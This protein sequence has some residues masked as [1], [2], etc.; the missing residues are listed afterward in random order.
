MGLKAEILSL[1]KERNGSFDTPGAYYDRIRH[2]GKHPTQILVFKCM[3][4]R[5]NLPLI[6]GVPMGILKPFRNIG[7]KFT[8]GDP[9][10]GRLVLDAVERVAR[11]GHSSLALCTFHFSKEHNDHRGC[12]G[13]KYNVAA[14]RE[15]AFTLKH[16]YDEIFGVGNSAISA[17]V[18][19]IETDEDALILC[20]EN[21]EELSIADCTE[22]SDAELTHKVLALYPDV[23]KEILADFLPLVLNN[24][25]HVAR[26]KKE[27]R[28]VLELVHN[29]NIIGVGRGFDW[30]H[31]PNRALIIGPYGHTGGTWREAVAVAGGIV[32]NNFKNNPDLKAGGALLLISAPY[33]DT[34]ERGMAIAKAKYF[35]TVARQ[36][37]EPFTDELSLDIL[38]GITDMSTMKYHPLTQI[39]HYETIS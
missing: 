17:I 39:S 6:T 23:P 33:A 19:G 5:I 37:L 35:A 12:A 15:G 14:S 13:H 8:L 30:L 29:E 3:D 11:E 24:R 1:N 22:L 25:A 20:G 4:G 21:G 32:L 9:Y 10:L 7:G 36:A 38:V 34:A 28:P 27:G 18:V 2:K 26:I 31:L 16:E